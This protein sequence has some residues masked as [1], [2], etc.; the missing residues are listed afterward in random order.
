MLCPFSIKG[1]GC[2]PVGDGYV[3]PSGSDLYIMCEPYY[4]A[5]GSTGCSI[6]CPGTHFKIEEHSSL[7]LDSITLRGSTGSAI[8]VESNASL[9][10][11]NSYF[12]VNQNAVSNGGAIFAD[13]GSDVYLSQTSFVNNTAHSGG[14]IKSLG[15]TQ[16]HNSH[17]LGNEATSHAVDMGGGA[18]YMGLSSTAYITASTFQNNAAVSFG[19]AILDRTR[20][21]NYTVQGNTGC[22]NI[23]QS[24]GMTCNGALQVFDG[25]DV[26]S[27]FEQICG[28]EEELVGTID[29][30]MP[31]SAPSTQPTVLVSEAPTVLPTILPSLAPN[32]LMLGSSNEPSNPPWESQSTDSP[33]RPPSKSPTQP[34][35]GYPTGKPV[36]VGGIESEVSESRASESPTHPSQ[37]PTSSAPTTDNDVAVGA[38][39]LLV[40]TAVPTIE[41]T[42]HTPISARPS[43]APSRPA[44]SPIVAPSIAP[45]AT[46]SESLKSPSKGPSPSP[47]ETSIPPSML[48]AAKPTQ[49]G[50][51]SEP[52]FYIYPTLM[53][54]LAEDED[55]SSTFWPDE[56]SSS[57]TMAPTEP[58]KGE[59][60]QDS[61]YEHTQTPEP[62]QT[63]TTIL[64]KT[65]SPTLLMTG[66]PSNKMPSVLEV[67][68]PSTSL[69]PPTSELEVA[70]IDVTELAPSESEAIDDQ[71]PVELEVTDCTHLNEFEEL[72]PKGSYRQGSLDNAPFDMMGLHSC[73]PSVNTANRGKLYRVVGEGAVMTAHTCSAFFQSFSFDTQLAIYTSDTAGNNLCTRDLT[74]IGANDDYCGKQSLVSW[75]AAEGQVYFIYVQGKTL[76]IANSPAMHQPFALTLTPTPGGSCNSAIALEVSPSTG[77]LELPVGGDPAGIDQMASIGYVWFGVAETD[78]SWFVASACQQDGT[79]PARLQVFQGSCEDGGLREVNI[80]ESECAFGQILAWLTTP[81]ESYYIKA[82]KI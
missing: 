59:S 35:S 22:N 64:D 26:C 48:P 45:T 57:W 80:I 33:T 50:T 42:L 37:A 49:P 43:P 10:A 55:E 51:D 76:G 56:D 75:F 41:A 36:M 73:G 52:L 9:T 79:F 23:A 63:S 53:P 29:E 58:I 6:D 74:C 82:Y 28:L 60:Y 78:F 1:D 44:F 68:A 17:F 71:L 77:K 15:N 47:S 34:L 61:N 5:A 3:V 31:S 72:S 8:R 67:V 46:P 30:A 21:G 32:R 39:L 2:P 4:Y 11:F 54:S 65:G 16:I 27:P 20:G 12:E 13:E 40:P 66:Q 14:A 25:I 19:P 62:T 69:S 81:G 18:L 7:T 24:L 70:P 38:L